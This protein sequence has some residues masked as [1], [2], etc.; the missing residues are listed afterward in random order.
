LKPIVKDEPKTAPEPEPEVKDEFT[1]FS[2]LA[3]SSLSTKPQGQ[4]KA[5]YNP[6]PTSYASG[7]ASPLGMAPAMSETTSEPVNN[8]DKFDLS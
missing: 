2:D 4:K 3:K 8:S 5:R 7:I 1:E 6:A